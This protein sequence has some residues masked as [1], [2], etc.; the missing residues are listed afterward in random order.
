MWQHIPAVIGRQAGY[1][2]DRSQPITG[3]RQSQTNTHAHPHSQGQCRMIQGSNLCRSSLHSVPTY[4]VIDFKTLMVFKALNGLATPYRVGL[5]YHYTLA[6][7]LRS[8]KHMLFI[9]PSNAHKKQRLLCSLQWLLVIY[10]TFILLLETQLFS[11]AFH[12]DRAGFHL[13][14]FSH[15][16]IG[17]IILI[18]FI[19]FFLSHLLCLI[20]FL[21]LYCTGFVEILLNSFLL[22]LQMF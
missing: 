13:F 6:R 8:T 18:R 1:T 21:L 12:L 11:P 9:V 22:Q 5:L 10:L 2:L 20:V 16:V 4:Y 19:F 3:P 7:I 14:F 17:N 15:A